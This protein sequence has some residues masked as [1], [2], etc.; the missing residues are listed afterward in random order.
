MG[1]GGNQTAD[2][3]ERVRTV[4]CGV[5]VGHEAVPCSLKAQVEA[6]LFVV[7]RQNPRAVGNKR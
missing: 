1:A 2:E 7:I 5:N 4:W 6:M 3:T